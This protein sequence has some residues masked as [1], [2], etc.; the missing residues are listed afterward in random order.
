MFF[1]DDIVFIVDTKGGIN[2]KLEFWRKMLESKGFTLNRTKMESMEVNLL[3][4]G[5]EVKNNKN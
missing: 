5:N 4:E 2:C 1:S 3:T